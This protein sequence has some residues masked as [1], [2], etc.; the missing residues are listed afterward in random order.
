LR[1]SQLKQDRLHKTLNSIVNTR[2]GDTFEARILV[3]DRFKLLGVADV[4]YTTNEKKARNLEQGTDFISKKRG[5]PLQTE[6]SAYQEVRFAK[7]HDIK[8]LLFLDGRYRN[9]LRY[10]NWIPL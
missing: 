7:Q 4:V 9:G 1:V 10:L 2:H 3:S 5:L 6:A 8:A